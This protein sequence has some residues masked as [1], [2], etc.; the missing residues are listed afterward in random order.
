MIQSVLTEPHAHPNFARKLLIVSALASVLLLIYSTFNI[1]SG[2]NPHRLEIES[3]G[4]NEPH[5][6]EAAREKAEQAWKKAKEAFEQ[7]ARKA[8]KTKEEKKR[9][10]QLKKQV[11][12]W[13][14]KKDW[15]GENHSQTKKGN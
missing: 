12:H 11:E 2:I 4:K 3:P 8:N 14:K 1:S 6:N 15:K 7:L 5:T 13:R 9:L 10:D